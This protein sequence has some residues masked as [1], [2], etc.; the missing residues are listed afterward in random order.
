[1][2]V[3]HSAALMKG[4]VEETMKMQILISRTL[5][6][7]YT[8]GFLGAGLVGGQTQNA[9]G[10]FNAPMIGA[11]PQTTVKS[12]KSNTSDRM[13]GGGG[14]GKG[15]AQGRVTGTSADTSDTLGNSQRKSNAGGAGSATARTPNGKTEQGIEAIPQFN[16][17][18]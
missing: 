8:L 6:V 2:E 15:A 16:L 12:S 17:R 10:T 3:V 9:V 11:A 1:M 5:L 14:T 4:Q 7:L 13:G 18:F